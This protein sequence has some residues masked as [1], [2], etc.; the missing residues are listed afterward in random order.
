MSCFVFRTV[1]PI[2]HTDLFLLN[3]WVDFFIPL[4]RPPI[5]HFL[6]FLCMGYMENRIKVNFSEGESVRIISGPFEDFMGVV[7]EI[8]AEKGKMKVSVSMFGR[9]TLVELEFSQVEKL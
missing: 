8:S 1:Y 4:G 3:V 5:C 6:V 9:E 7:Q 2:V